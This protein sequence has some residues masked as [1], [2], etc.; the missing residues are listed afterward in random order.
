MEYKGIQ[1]DDDA[2]EFRHCS[3]VLTGMKYLAITTALVLASITT[4]ARAQ[5]TSKCQAT[6]PARLAEAQQAIMQWDAQRKAEDG[7]AKSPQGKREAQLV[8]FFSE[9]CRFLEEIEIIVRKLDDRNSFVCDAPKP[10][11]MTSKLMVE[12]M[13]VHPGVQDTGEH[14]YENVVCRDADPVSLAISSDNDD[15]AN[16]ARVALVQCYENDSKVCGELRKVA[17]E[18]LEHLAKVSP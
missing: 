8:E 18:Q 2:F 6:F 17:T 12:L 9:H 16:N 14:A 11:G 3:A 7:R 13:S 10:K 15:P 5:D 4:V 1:I